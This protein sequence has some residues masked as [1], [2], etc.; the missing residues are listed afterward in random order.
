MALVFS[1]H[2]TRPRRHLCAHVAPC[3]SIHR[4]ACN[5]GENTRTIASSARFGTEIILCHKRLP[6]KLTSLRLAGKKKSAACWKRLARTRYLHIWFR[7]CC[8]LTVIPPLEWCGWGRAFGNSAETGR[9]Q[10][11]FCI[12]LAHQLVTERPQIWEKSGRPAPVGAP[13]TGQAPIT[14][15]MSRSASSRTRSIMASRNMKRATF[16]D[17]VG[18]A[19]ASR[20]VDRRPEKSELDAAGFEQADAGTVAPPARQQARSGWLAIGVVRS[21]AAS[22]A[23]SADPGR[24][25][26]SASEAT[27]LLQAAGPVRPGRGAEEQDR[28]AHSYVLVP[29]RRAID[30]GLPSLARLASS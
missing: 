25:E 15:R 18:S 13:A 24:G 23:V 10:E 16:T 8:G 6:P 5:G 11:H 30:F 27:G 7:Q 26:G 1:R 12:A 14:R 21:C 29:P 22:L 28:P 20:K 2:V 9:I 4:L 17:S 19:S 3:L